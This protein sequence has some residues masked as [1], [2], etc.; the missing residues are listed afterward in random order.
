MGR[1]EMIESV[2]KIAR[3]AFGLLAMVVMA[4]SAFAAD[5]PPNFVIV[6]ADDLGYNDVGC[7][8]SP[9]IKTPVIDRMAR[10]GMRFNSFYVQPICG[11]SRTAL[12]TGCYPMRVAERG[13]VKR[14][15]PVVHADEITI[16]EV[17]KAKGYATGMFGKWDLGGHSNVPADWPAKPG[18]YH[19][20][21][22]PMGQ[23]FD[24]HFGTPSSNDSNTNTVLMRNGV[25]IEKPAVQAT[26]TR[27]YTDNAIDF[28]EANKDKPFFV[29]LA[30]TMPH[31]Q[32]H[33][34]ESFLGKSA[35]GL[36]GDTVEEIDFNLGRLLDALKE[37]GLD[38]NTWVLFTS[39]NGPWWIKKDHGGSAFPLRS[40]KVT[41]WEGG[42]RTPAVLRAP[43]RVPAGAVVDD[44]VASVDILPT[45]AALA[46][47]GVPDD[48]VIDGV[49]LTDLIT[50]K[51]QTSPRDHYYYYLWSHLQAV[52]QGPWKLILSRPQNP[53]WLGP[54]TGRHVDPKDE[55][56]VDSPELYHLG[57]DIGESNDVA[58]SHPDVVARLLK[59][60]EKA[61]A[62]VGDY[63]R[64]G[65][66]ARF[67]D[68]GP[69]RPAVEHWTRGQAPP[70]F[71][72]RRE[73]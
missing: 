21:L 56:A 4:G 33:A 39:D 73:N 18:G 31:T 28:I 15:H 51:T 44:I 55:L 64:I 7:Y 22:L 3:S 49:D 40:A 6:F 41:C 52:R 27:R 26:L 47:A 11:P 46:G 38:D 24:T 2:K 58:V 37:R 43:G 71:K 36:Y 61:R 17:L 63:D 12:M 72:Q 8:G 66:G 70:N 16:A 10:E 62:D 48:R 53:P 9:L 25:V 50:G 5:R 57:R 69:R 14:T 19:Y 34:S 67:Y 60:A 29:Y 65:A 32:L 30:H 35:R 42:V 1:V 20:D 45:F 23:G 13:N 54:L 68:E 59:L